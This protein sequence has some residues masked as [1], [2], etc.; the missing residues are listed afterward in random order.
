MTKTIFDMLE[1]AKTPAVRL[2][3]TPTMALELIQAN[4]M[5]RPLDQNTVS[6]ISRQILAGKWKFNGDTIKVS[7]DRNILDGQH[8]LHAV[9]ET[10]QTIETLVVIDVE[11]EAF[12]TIDTLRKFRTLGDTVAVEGQAK[13]R[14]Q[15]GQALAWL[16]RYERGTLIAYRAPQ[17]RI[18]NSDIKEAWR[19]NTNIVRAV[20][21][22]APLRRVVNTGL[23][24]F[25]YY[26]VSNQNAELA[27]RM[28]ETLNDPSRSAAK[29]PFFLLC[30]YLTGDAFKDAVR[31]IALM[32]KA[33][34]Y[35]FNG[36]Q[37]GTLEWRQQGTSPEKFPVLEVSNLRKIRA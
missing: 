16:L 36:S 14:Q 29:D 15:I 17:N 23:L 25:Y 33:A 35:A 10:K 26:L 20:E 6:R 1:A 24:G 34:N 28:I 9:I 22:A 3:L 7:L 4:K 11:A 12:D 21:R 27:E 2:I 32:I 8:R 37:I 19:A 18:E 30:Q 31:T 13:Y 5:N